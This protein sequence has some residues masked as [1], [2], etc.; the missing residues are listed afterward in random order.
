M[1]AH[2]RAKEKGNAARDTMTLSR[3]YNEAWRCLLPMNV[4]QLPPS[5]KVQEACTGQL[6]GQLGP[7]SCY[8]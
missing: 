6:C 5:V 7:R 8:Q 4:A 2:C 3:V 1:A